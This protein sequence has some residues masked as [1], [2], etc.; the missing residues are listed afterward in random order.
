MVRVDCSDLYEICDIFVN[1]NPQTNKT[2][3][4][5]MMLTKERTHIYRSKDGSALPLDVKGLAEFVA[6]YKKYPV[7]GTGSQDK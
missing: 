5:S 4:T 1:W 7:H 2:Y 3:P 6:N